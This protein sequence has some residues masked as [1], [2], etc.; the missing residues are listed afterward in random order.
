MSEIKVLKT[1]GFPVAE[2]VVT[3]TAGSITHHKVLLMKD[4]FEKLTGG[5]TTP[6]N[7]IEKSFE[8]LLSRESNTSILSQFNLEV[9]SSYF[10]EY[11]QTIKEKL[12]S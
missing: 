9:I 10:P 12:S 7:F 5:N 3:V 2:Y 8:F 6:E 4:Y 11:E 1:K